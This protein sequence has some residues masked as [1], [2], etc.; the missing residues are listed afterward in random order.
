MGLLAGLKELVQGKHLDWLLSILEELAALTDGDSLAW[1]S[2]VSSRSPM[3]QEGVRAG[4]EVPGMCAQILPWLL[5][6]LFLMV[7]KS[8]LED[9]L[10]REQILS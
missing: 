2:E 4:Q 7:S 5:T 8:S 1:L 3:L 10:F 9:C 6:F